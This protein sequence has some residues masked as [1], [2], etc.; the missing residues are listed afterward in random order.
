MFFLFFTPFSILLTSSKARTLYVS[1]VCASFRDREGVVVIGTSVR[2]LARLQYRNQRIPIYLLHTEQATHTAASES[3]TYRLSVQQDK[4]TRSISFAALSS[5][6]L[7]FLPFRTAFSLNIGVVVPAHAGHLNPAVTLGAELL[8]RGNKV[9]LITTPPGSLAAER[10][11]LD[12][13]PIGIE[14]HKSGALRVDL[15]QEGR[16][17]DLSA[18]WHTLQL[19]KREERIL[20]RDLP[21]VIQATGVDALCVDQLLPA[22][23][24]I[25]EV[26]GIPSAVLCNALPLHLD[27]EVPPF[28]TTWAPSNGSRL[29]RLRNRVSNMA[30]IVAAAPLYLMLNRYRAKNGLA[31][32]RGS[33]VQAVGKIQVTQIPSFVD[34][35]RTKLPSHFF[36]SGPWHKTNRDTKVS[37]PWER[38]DG[39]PIVYASLGSVQTGLQSLYL[40]VAEACGSM[41]NVQ[42]VMS[43]G[44]KGASLPANRL[45]SNAIVVD[46]APQLE[47]LQKASVVLTHG[48]LNTALETLSCGLPIVIVPLANDQP[49]IAARLVNL[50]V[51][52]AVPAARATKTPELLKEAFIKVMKDPS[53][54]RAARRHQQTLRNECPTLAQTAEL[55]ETGLCRTDGVLGRDDPEAKRI[56]E[57]ISPPVANLTTI[58]V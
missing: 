37:F 8:R 46:Y 23:M 5:V 45:P 12:F 13:E 33:T 53:F 26:H 47:L 30:I 51:A 44:R 55:L 43:L 34:F 35:P 40:A 49:G 6:V 58:L 18:F 22:A 41:G 3:D 50:G 14:E 56:L 9:T 17:R 48:G 11:G 1:L 39:R 29:R 32:H 16:L 28:V 54:R 25:A 27:P 15:E 42:L 4:M 57:T 2:Y 24:D 19:F 7:L 31:W 10:S 21:G 38:L 52:E 36:Y 20:L